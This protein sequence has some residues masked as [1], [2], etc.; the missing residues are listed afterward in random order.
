MAATDCSADKACCIMGAGAVY[1]LPTAQQ[2]QEPTQVTAL[3]EGA[4]SSLRPE[5]ALQLLL[6]ALPTAADAVVF[7]DSLSLMTSLL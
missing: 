4:V 7:T 2:Q 1:Y 3:I 5:A 6:Q